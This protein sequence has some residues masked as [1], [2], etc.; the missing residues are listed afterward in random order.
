M[1]ESLSPAAATRRER[2]AAGGCGAHLHRGRPGVE[3]IAYKLRGHPRRL[4]DELLRGVEGARTSFVSLDH[5]TDEELEH[6]H[7]EFTRL[8]ERYGTLV[9][10]DI[11]IV[12]RELGERKRSE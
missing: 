2:G 4:L 8:S 7:A 1:T 11:A 6:V 9:G 5:L 12:K 3:F 10:D